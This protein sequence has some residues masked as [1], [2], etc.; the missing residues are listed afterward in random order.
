[1]LAGRL[2]PEL[3]AVVHTWPAKWKHRTT[4]YLQGGDWYQEEEEGKSARLA[5]ARELGCLVSTGIHLIQNLSLGSTSFYK[6][7]FYRQ[8]SFR[9]LGLQIKQSEGSKI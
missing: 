9:N 7:L 6:Q 1:M 8:Q 4:A 5:L 2:C 3:G